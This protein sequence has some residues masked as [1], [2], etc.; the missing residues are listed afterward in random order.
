MK[1]IEKEGSNQDMCEFVQNELTDQKLQQE[2]LKEFVRT[3]KNER[4]RDELAD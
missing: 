4:I 2:I 1:R 3:M